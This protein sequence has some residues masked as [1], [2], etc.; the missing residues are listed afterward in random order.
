M[1]RDM[2]PT[3]HGRILAAELVGPLVLMLGGPGV[4]VLLPA[5]G[6]LPEGDASTGA[7]LLKILLITLGFGFSLLTMW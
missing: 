6:L 2:E 1:V 4:A 3:N 7:G 5:R